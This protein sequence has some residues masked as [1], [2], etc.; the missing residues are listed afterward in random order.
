[1][2][3]GIVGRKDRLAYVLG[4]EALLLRQRLGRGQHAGHV[5]ELGLHLG[6]KGANVAVVRAPPR[7]DYLAGDGLEATDSGR[8]FLG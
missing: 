3:A 1:M 6:L 5:A 8:A 4:T 2:G 7:A